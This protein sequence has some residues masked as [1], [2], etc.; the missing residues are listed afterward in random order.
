MF[1]EFICL[2]FGH[3]WEISELSYRKESNPIKICKN[4]PIYCQTF[5]PD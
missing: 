4:C 1:N 5:S 2:L 3:N